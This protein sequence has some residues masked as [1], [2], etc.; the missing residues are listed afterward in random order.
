MFA[1]G[2]HLSAFANANIRFQS[3]YQSTSVT[4][5]FRYQW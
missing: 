3:D 1:T 5:G 2:G 4:A